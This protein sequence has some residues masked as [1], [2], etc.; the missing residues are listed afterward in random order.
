MSAPV[1]L[2]LLLENLRELSDRNLQLR[3][4]VHGDEDEMSSFSEA[5]CG[6]FDDAG[7][8]WALDSPDRQGQFSGN[9]WRVARSLDKAIGLVPHDESPEVILAHPA[10]VKVRSLSSQLQLLIE[11]R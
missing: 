1:D 9:F 4:W 8:T 10:M 6:A 11:T 2:E 5:A 3:L 7:L